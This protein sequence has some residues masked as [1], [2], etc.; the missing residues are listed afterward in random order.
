MK[1][2]QEAGVPIDE[3]GGSCSQRTSPC[4]GRLA[5]VLDIPP[6]V[7]RVSELPAGCDV[8][9]PTLLVTRADPGAP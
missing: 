9:P 3:L 8:N 7:P 4:G 2:H 6:A 5:R 1:E